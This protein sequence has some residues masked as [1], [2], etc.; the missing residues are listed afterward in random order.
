MKHI[1]SIRSI[2][3]KRFTLAALLGVLS[4]SAWANSGS[5]YGKLTAETDPNSDSN[6]AGKIYVSTTALA[7]GTEPTNLANTQEV[8]CSATVVKFL[9]STLYQGTS[10]FYCYAR[11]PENTKG[12]WAGWYDNSGALQGGGEK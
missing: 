9:G 6:G 1:Y 3:F 4:I 11:E 10:T 2:Y 8:V 7:E 5:T 12:L